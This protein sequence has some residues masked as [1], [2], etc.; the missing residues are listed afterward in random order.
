MVRQTIAQP[1]MN[2]IIVPAY[3][4]SARRM[5]SA[6]ETRM[7]TPESGATIR[8]VR[9]LRMGAALLA[10]VALVACAGLT[11][12][13]GVLPTSAEQSASNLAASASPTPSA[14]PS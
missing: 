11:P 1:R 6:V 4:Q 8:A 7:L 12:A 2:R 9:L 3:D 14:T 13:S 10:A 5:T